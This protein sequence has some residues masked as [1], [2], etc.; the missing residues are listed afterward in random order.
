MSKKE[1]KKKKVRKKEKKSWNQ[2]E[3]QA[4]ETD[5]VLERG[6]SDGGGRL[7]GGRERGRVWEAG[8]DRRGE[9]KG[10]RKGGR[11]GRGE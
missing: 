3:K 11:E 6:F 1:W 10:E 9:R 4:E 2:D 7:G 8:R 5:V